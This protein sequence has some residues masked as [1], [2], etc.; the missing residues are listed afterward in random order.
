M[1]ASICFSNVEQRV[2]SRIMEHCPEDATQYSTFGR[3]TPSFKGELSGKG[4]RG[5]K[6]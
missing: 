5:P 6:H 1:R 4:P 3:V 2:S